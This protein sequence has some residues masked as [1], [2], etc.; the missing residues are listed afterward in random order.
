M[1]QKTKKNFSISER[2][3]EVA[4]LYA[5][6]WDQE[7]IAEELEVSQATVSRDISFLMEQAKKSMGEEIKNLVIRDLMSLE[8]MEKEAAKNY[9]WLKP[10]ELHESN[11]YML[12]SMEKWALIRLKILERKSKLLGLDQPPKDL[13]EGDQ[14]DELPEVVFHF[15][16]NGRDPDYIRKNEPPEDT[17]K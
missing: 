8:A 4:R 6:R 13:F 1:T 14:G 5:M 3:R 7:E 11:I 10:I 2:R 9:E 16:D 12:R 17:E 15:P